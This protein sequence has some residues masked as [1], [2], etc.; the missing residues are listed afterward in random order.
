MSSGN[1]EKI[2]ERFLRRLFNEMEKRYRVERELS[3]RELSEKHK[4]PVIFVHEILQ[5]PLKQDFSQ[6]FPEIEMAS[7]Y[8][9]KFVVGWLIEEAIK[10]LT[11]SR[12]K[13]CYKIIDVDG[14]KYVLAGSMDVFIAEDSTAIEVKYLTSMYGAPH[15]HHIL[16][17]QLYL[18]LAGLNHGEL[19]MFSPEGTLFEEVTPLDEDHV[20]E[21]VRSY[22]ERLNIPR[23]DWECTRCLYEEWCGKSL[24][25]M[26]KK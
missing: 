4:A 21:L 10:K 5:C 26:R 16:Q 20:K 19:W 9:S 11:N 25:K 22:V 12:E 7:I 18:F 15:I 3:R 13:P 23:W 17:L 24:R 1:A 8:N 6:Q 14:E 2:S